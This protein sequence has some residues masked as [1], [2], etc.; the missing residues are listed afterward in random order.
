[1]LADEPGG[2]VVQAVAAGVRDSGVEFRDAGLGLD[3]AG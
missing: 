3:R 2:Q 1:V